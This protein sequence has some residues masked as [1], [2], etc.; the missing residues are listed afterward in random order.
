MIH[1]SNNATLDDRMHLHLCN[2]KRQSKEGG[3]AE[4]L[5]IR[6]EPHGA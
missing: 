6:P 4:G 3:T 2:M 1:N 5:P